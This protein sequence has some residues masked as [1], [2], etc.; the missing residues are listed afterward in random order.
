M[1]SVLEQ[2]NKPFRAGSPAEGVAVG[3]ARRPELPRI[4]R[5]ALMT[6]LA[7]VSI[8]LLVAWAS[9]GLWDDTMTGEEA[10]NALLVRDELFGD[11]IGAGD[12]NEL[13]ALVAPG[14]ELT[15][16]STTLIGPGG[17]LVLAQ[18]LERVE[19]TSAMLLLDV[20]AQGDLVM[21]TWTIDQ[22]QPSVLLGFESPAE[23]D[24][25]VS[26]QMIL[27]M[28]DRQITQMTLTTWTVD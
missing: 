22:P 18:E 27:T 12:Y 9:S 17:M 7:I 10:A 15:V 21:A 5:D 3:E 16:P 25:Y 14:A 24:D 8:A 19:S 2:S 4:L 26:G 6:A 13:D 1:E 11:L 23:D 28:D 20:V